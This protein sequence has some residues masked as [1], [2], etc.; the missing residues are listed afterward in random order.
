MRPLTKHPVTVRAL[1]K[2]WVHLI[3]QDEAEAKLIEGKVMK[4]DSS[5]AIFKQW[6]PH[7]DAR[8]E[9]TDSM[10]VWVRIPGLLAHLWHEEFFRLFGNQLGS[11][12]EHDAS[13]ITSVDTSMARILVSVDIRGE[14]P[15]ATD[16]V[17]GMDPFLLDYEGIPF[18]CRRCDEHDHN[19]KECVL[20]M[21]KKV[22]RPSDAQVGDAS[23]SASYS[24]ASSLWFHVLFRSTLLTHPFRSL[25]D[26]GPSPSLRSPGLRLM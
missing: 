17:E 24:T 19:A 5:P 15:G 8:R 6:T 22:H 9:K 13:Y 11:Y 10:P 2:G 4:L 18:R 1:A 23:G 14:L 12:L 7:F 3:L 21:N 16:L 20:P 26:R 25:K